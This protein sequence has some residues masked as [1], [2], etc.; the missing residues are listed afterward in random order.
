MPST[1]SNE[2]AFKDAICKRLRANDIFCWRAGAGPYSP[3]GVPDILAIRFGRLIA[4]EAK[5]PGKKP[6]S[7]QQRWLDDLNAAGA[8]AFWADDMQL[9]VETL[10]LT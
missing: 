1:Y 8:Q 9:I 3:A 7:L 4:I 2:S 6:T 5:M 10:G